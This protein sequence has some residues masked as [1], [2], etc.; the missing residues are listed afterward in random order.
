MDERLHTLA[1]AQFG[2]FGIGDAARVGVTST[3]IANL[4]RRKVI[5]RIRRGAYVLTSRYAVADLAAQRRLRV[6]A[7]LRSRPDDRASH[8]SALAIL[9]IGTFGVDEKVVELESRSTR[10][11]RRQ[12][13]LAVNPWSGGDSWMLDSYSCVPPAVAC[14]QVAATSGFTAAVCAM[15]GALYLQRC[16]REEIKHAAMALPRIHRAVAL[17]AL[18][19]TDPCAESVGE[20]RTRIILADAG[21]TVESQVQIFDGDTLL[22]RVDLLIDGCVIVEFDGLMK[23][24]G[25]NGRAALAAEKAR[26]ERLS[27]LGYEVVRIVWSELTTPLAIVARVR[28]ARRLARERRNAMAR[29]R[30]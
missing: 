5:Q 6:M 22:G 4:V 23:Y 17:R 30:V 20:S 28:D 16:T 15:D 13:R 27:R 18:D 29:A 2:A 10:R 19:A 11:R 24:E 7:V 8:H 12:G 9:G 14:V 1:E 26:E 3:E 25:N 21:F